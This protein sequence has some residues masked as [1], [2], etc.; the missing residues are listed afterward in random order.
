[1]EIQKTNEINR[2]LDFYYQLL[3]KKQQDYI[4][5]YY[6]D[7]YSLGEIAA[8][9]DVSR[10]AV[11]DNIRRTEKTLENYESRLHLASDYRKRQGAIKELR[12]YVT[13]NYAQDDKLKQKVDKLLIMDDKEV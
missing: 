9:F 13:K 12:D 2:L 8:Y 4:S 3:T 6:Q 5:L 1:M 7:D 11:Y 10:Q